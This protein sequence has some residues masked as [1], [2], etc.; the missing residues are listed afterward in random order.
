MKNIKNIVPACQSLD[1]EGKKML[2]SIGKK[3]LF[4]S[5][6]NAIV[7]IASTQIQNVR[8]YLPMCLLISWS[9]ISLMLII[10]LKLIVACYG[11]KTAAN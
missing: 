9:I 1:T 4:Y 10:T 3:Y 2:S 8:T 6:L 11:T 5:I 7:M